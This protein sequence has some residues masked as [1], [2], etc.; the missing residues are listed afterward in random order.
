MS[1]LLNVGRCFG[2]QVAASGVYRG[3]WSKL[4]SSELVCSRK[5][6]YGKGMRQEKFAYRRLCGMRDGFR[7]LQAN[8]CG[9]RRRGT[10]LAWNTVLFLQKLECEAAAARE[11]GQEKAR[12]QDRYKVPVRQACLTVEL[13][14]KST[15]AMAS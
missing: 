13:Q 5:R 15:I 12:S 6:T 3:S 2:W 14:G 1:V 9:L 7:H 10:V 11:R 4:C 8:V